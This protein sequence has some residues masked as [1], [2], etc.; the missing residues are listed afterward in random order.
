MKVRLT[1]LYAGPHMSAQPGSVVEFS[2]AEGRELIAGRYGVLVPDTPTATQNIP[3]AAPGEENASVA[4][5]ENAAR[6]T[7]RGARGRST[8]GAPAPATE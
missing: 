1:S 3:A 5:P 4:P 8:A 7:G 2:D 6:R